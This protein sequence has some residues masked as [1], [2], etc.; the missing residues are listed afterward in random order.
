MQEMNGKKSGFVVLVGRSN[1]G[2]STLLNALVGSKIAIV[3]PKPQTTRL[4]IRG[5]VTDEKR[6]QIVFVDTPGFFLKQDAVSQRLNT[7]VREQLEGV[8]AVLYVIDPA[9]APGPE[10]AHIQE[11][12]KK[13]SIPVI[14]A[15]NKCDLTEAQRPYT[16]AA[17]DL[18]V[19]QAATF[20]ISALRH[21]ELNRVMDTLFDLMPEGDW[22]YPPM[23]LTDLSHREWIEELI[24]EKVFLRLRQELPYTT[25]V[26]VVDI[27]AASEETEHII[28]HIWTTD[29]RYR[30]MLIGAKASMIKHIGMD[31]RT[32]LEQSMGKKVYLELDVRV[33]PEWMKRF[34]Y[35]SRT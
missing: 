35:A 24:R 18:D 26:E 1:V 30:R 33:D 25:K 6:G 13:L 31:A 29:E 5:I 20:Q 12:L 2:K 7:L 16:Q 23:Q 15:V 17:L 8:D 28:A 14:V 9:R 32:E 19:G 3:T 21:Q 27:S 22:F 34:L 11:I 4:P 10:E